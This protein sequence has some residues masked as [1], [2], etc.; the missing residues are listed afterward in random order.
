MVE[1][2]FYIT[3]II[4]IVAVIFSVIYWIQERKNRF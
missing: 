1:L 3:V 4:T 2:I